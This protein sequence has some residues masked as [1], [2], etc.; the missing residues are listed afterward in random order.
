MKYVLIA[1]LAFIM[2]P[3]NIGAQE[4]SNFILLSDGTYKTADGKDYMIIPFEGKSAHQIYQELASNVGSTFNEPSKVMSCVEDTSIKIRALS[5]LWY[6]GKILGTVL[7]YE[8]HYQ[9]E[10]RIRDGR[11]RVSAPIIENPVYSFGSKDRTPANYGKLVSRWFKKGELKEGDKYKYDTVVHEMNR[12]INSI[13][14]AT[15]IQDDT[16]EW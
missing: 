7:G 9:L 5:R 15:A 6:A 8:G 4:L 16:E 3:I 14:Y 11:V 10:F 1:L 2:L 12:I 13:L